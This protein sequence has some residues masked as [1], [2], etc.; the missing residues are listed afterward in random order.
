MNLIKPALGHESAVTDFV[1]RCLEFG[2][3]YADICGSSVLAKKFQEEGYDAWLKLVQ[4][5]AI[6]KE[7]HSQHSLEPGHTLLLVEHLDPGVEVSAEYLKQF[8]LLDAHSR[9]AGIVT[10]QHAIKDADGGRGYSW[11]DVQEGTGDVRL[12]MLPCYRDSVNYMLS[13][14]DLMAC[15]VCE[16]LPYKYLQMYLRNEPGRE[17]LVLAL[18]SCN[19]DLQGGDGS[20]Y[21]PYRYRVDLR[22]AHQLEKHLRKYYR[23]E[24]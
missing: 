15:V 5:N 24:E 14:S 11:F 22:A 9:L 3:A 16:G 10:V 2:D 18:R 12:C 19:F 17:A 1:S 6:A 21:A 13:L 8:P 4:A 23:K 7:R 20:T